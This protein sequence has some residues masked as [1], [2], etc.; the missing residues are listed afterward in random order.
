[1]TIFSLEKIL[2]SSFRCNNRKFYCRSSLFPGARFVSSDNEDKEEN[3]HTE[4]D[5]I[6][7]IITQN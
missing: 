5:N 1:M 3:P 6:V 4:D 7:V 2:W